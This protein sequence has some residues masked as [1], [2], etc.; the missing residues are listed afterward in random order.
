MII[1]RI[2]AQKIMEKD[3]VEALNELF[4]TDATNLKELSRQL[5]DSKVYRQVEVGNWPVDKEGWDAVSDMLENVQQHSEYFFLIWGT[6]HN[7]KT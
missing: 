4:G 1:V 6:D 2:D 7:I 5:Q 3:P